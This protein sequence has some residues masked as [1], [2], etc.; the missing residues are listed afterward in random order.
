MVANCSSKIT[1]FLKHPRLSLSL[2]HTD[3]THPVLTK[4]LETRHSVYKHLQRAYY[5]GH[6]RD[7][8]RSSC[9][10][11]LLL[12]RPHRLFE[13][14]LPSENQK[15]C[16]SLRRTNQLLPQTLQ[17]FAWRRVKILADH[18]KVIYIYCWELREAIGSDGSLFPMHDVDDGNT[19]SVSM[20]RS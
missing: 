18:Q 15:K 7:T 17:K 13:L 2:S 19:F 1:P 6:P 12:S 4:A 16:F 20:M 3:Q 14:F 10:Y 11:F 9:E 5:L 8:R